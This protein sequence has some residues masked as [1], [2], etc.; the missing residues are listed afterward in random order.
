M[1]KLFKLFF[2]K[3]AKGMGMG[4]PV[5]KKFVEMHEGTLDIRASSARHQGNDLATHEGAP[6]DEADSS[7]A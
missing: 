5:T 3:K 1:D 2:T 6:E 7:N 4:L